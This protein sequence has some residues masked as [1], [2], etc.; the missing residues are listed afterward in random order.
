MANKFTKEQQ[1]QQVKL[2][3]INFRLN[4]ERVTA[5]VRPTISSVIGLLYI[6]ESMHSAHFL[7]SVVITLL[8]LVAIMHTLICIVI[9][10]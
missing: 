3:L 2:T 4:S 10:S 7:F 5:S 1:Q 9:A 6:V 8:A